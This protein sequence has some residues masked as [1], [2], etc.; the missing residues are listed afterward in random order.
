M[1]VL[2]LEKI[3]IFILFE[4]HDGLEHK[5]DPCA[6]GENSSLSIYLSSLLSFMHNPENY[7]SWL[8]ETFE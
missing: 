1:L 8:P 3:K 6:Y 4:V 2:I 5:F 7:E